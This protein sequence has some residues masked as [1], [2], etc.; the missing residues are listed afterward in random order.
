MSETDKT[1]YYAVKLKSQFRD[2]WTR[3]GSPTPALFTSEAKARATIK[4]NSRYDEDEYDIV[5]FAEV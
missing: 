5:K 1:V 3:T 4:Q 2:Y